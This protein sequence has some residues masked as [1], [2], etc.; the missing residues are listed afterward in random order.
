M[1]LIHVGSSP[2]FAQDFPKARPLIEAHRLA[3]EE[4]ERLLA[5]WE[6]ASAELSALEP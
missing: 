4:L 2:D 3:G 1:R 6:S 5:R